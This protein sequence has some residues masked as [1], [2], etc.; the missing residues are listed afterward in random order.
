[1]DFK[2]KAVLAVT[3]SFFHFEKENLSKR[4]AIGY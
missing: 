1:M 3:P 4:K 2:S